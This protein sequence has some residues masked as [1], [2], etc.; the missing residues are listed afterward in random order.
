MAAAISVKA[1]LWVIGSR[2]LV[3]LQCSVARSNGASMMMTN[4]NGVEGGTPVELI[5][6]A[7]R[8]SAEHANVCQAGPGDANADGE[9]E[10]AERLEEGARDDNNC[11]AALDGGVDDL[12][13][14]Q[15]WEA[16]IRKYK[17][18]QLCDA[19]LLQLEGKDDL[20][21]REQLRLERAQAVADAVEALAKLHSKETREKLDAFLKLDAGE[22][23]RLSVPLS[24]TFENSRAPLFWF[25][26]FVRLFPRG[27]CMERCEERSCRL[28]D[29]R[30]VKVLLTRADFR[31]W[32]KDVEFVASS[33]TCSCVAP[34]CRRCR[35]L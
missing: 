12:T 9:E 19:E 21:R 11:A 1:S 28:P 27:D 10:G 2:S 25:R 31:L 29:F 6:G 8:I 35:W 5:Q 24:A 33:T 7:S 13:P 16:I 30:W 14:V 15:L 22:A 4:C 3:H 17:V 18:A 20:T 34:R 23:A 32:C 26:C